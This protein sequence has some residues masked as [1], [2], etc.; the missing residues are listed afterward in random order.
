MLADNR[1]EVGVKFDSL[2]AV[3]CPKPQKKI[4]YNFFFVSECIFILSS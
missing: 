1:K 4:L 2:L 3:A